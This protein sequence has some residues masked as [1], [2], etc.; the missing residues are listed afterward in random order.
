MY[1]LNLGSIV[2]QRTMGQDHFTLPAGESPGCVRGAVS[3]SNIQAV[4]SSS[5]TSERPEKRDQNQCILTLLSLIL[6]F[7][8]LRFSIAS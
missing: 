1:V 8:F 5:V 6:F 2:L 7:F 3:S 4:T